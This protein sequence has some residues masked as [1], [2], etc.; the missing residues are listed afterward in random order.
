MIPPRRATRYEPLSLVH[1]TGT[2]SVP[3][4]GGVGRPA[5]VIVAVM[6]TGS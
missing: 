5:K 1:N 3:C 2:P 4:L 6:W